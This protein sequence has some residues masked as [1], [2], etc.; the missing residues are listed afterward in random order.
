MMRAINFIAAAAMLS[1]SLFGDSAERD[2]GIAAFNAGK[3]SV[4]LEKLS[5]AARDKSD[6]TAQLFLALTEAATGN[7]QA[8]LPALVAEP[9]DR[10]GGIAAVKCYSSA[11][12]VA[13]EFAILDEL[14][15][16]Y[17]NDA[18][19]LYLS[20]KEHMKAFNGATFAMFQRTPSSY[21]V[22]ELSGEIFE[23]QNRFEDAVAE[24]R[25]A[26]EMNPA[27]PDLHFRLGRA[28]LLE[29]HSEEMLQAA[30][31]EFQAE[32]KLNPEDASCQFQ[33]GQIA[34][35][36]TKPEDARAHFE[37]ALK[38]SPNFVQALLALGKMESANKNYARA[39]E[40]L[41]KAA[42]LEPTN[43]AA[44]YALLTAYRNS[45]QMQKAKE[46][47]TILDKL[48]QPDDGEFSNFLKKLGEKPA[49]P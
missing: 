25:K 2:A 43:E 21:R 36:E 26:I 39:I 46:E 32:L 37:A 15:R 34:Q 14:L 29:N 30:A 28:L 31:K 49:Q 40:L 19:V 5:L 23:V 16:K 3:Y 13:H 1:L 17:P 24:Y 7:C 20:A 8:A 6:K 35:V 47:K 42:Q 9:L 11:G 38:L 48:Q 33:L 10:M 41:S 44:H 18:D 12:D 45:G 22:H 27:A 4:A